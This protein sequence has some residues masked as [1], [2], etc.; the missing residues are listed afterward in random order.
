MALRA[1]R[2]LA[3]LLAQSVAPVHAP[4]SVHIGQTYAAVHTVL[5][6][7]SLVQPTLPGPSTRPDT[8]Q[9]LASVA[10]D[11]V[12]AR[13]LAHAAESLGAMA[14]LAVAETHRADDAEVR[15]A[16]KRGIFALAT[17]R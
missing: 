10:L 8:H 15:S 9:A 7:V 16:L 11:A 4:E 2:R 1:V 6:L 14:D 17:A 13:D 5:A 3:P 12:R